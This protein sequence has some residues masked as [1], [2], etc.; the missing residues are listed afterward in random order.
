MVTQVLTQEILKGLPELSKDLSFSDGE[1]DGLKYIGFCIV[2]IYEDKDLKYY[3]GELKDFLN[4][5]DI[6]IIKNWNPENHNYF[7]HNY[8]KLDFENY[9]YLFQNTEFTNGRILMGNLFKKNFE[10]RLEL[11]SIQQAYLMRKLHGR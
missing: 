8:H 1:F 3:C 2:E 4:P 6:M 10:N 5:S 9:L 7:I 11:V